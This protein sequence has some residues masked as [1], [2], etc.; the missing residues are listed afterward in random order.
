MIYQNKNFSDNDIEEFYTLCN[1]IINELTDE[2]NKYHHIRWNSNQYQILLG[3]WIYHFN[4]IILWRYYNIQRCFEKV[5]ENIV[6]VQPDYEYIHHYDF[7][8]LLNSHL[9][10]IVE[11]IIKYEK[12]PHLKFSTYGKVTAKYN[13][14]NYS[15]DNLIIDAPYFGLNHNRIHSEEYSKIIQTFANIGSVIDWEFAK[16]EV[17]VDTYWRSRYIGEKASTIYEMCLNLSRLYLPIAFLEGFKPIYN[18][19]STY[20]ISSIYTPIGIIWNLPLKTILAQNYLKNNIYLH[21]HGGG[22]GMDKFHPN[23][24]YERKICKNFFTLGWVEDSKTTP[25]SSRARIKKS[26]INSGILIKT[27]PNHRYS[28]DFFAFSMDITIQFIRNLK[29]KNCHISHYRVQPGEDEK[30]IYFTRLKYKLEDAILPDKTK[31]DGEY[32]MHVMNY[33]G[34]SFLESIAANIP[35]ICLIDNDLLDYRDE[36]INKL[37][38]LI[39]VGIVHHCGKEAAEHVNSISNDIKSWWLSD[40]VQNIRN[41]FFNQYARFND[42]WLAEFDNFFSNYKK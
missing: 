14:V 23:E 31:N 16:A 34:T 11:K 35:T 28:N 38:K 39:K 36:C 29:S 24:K 27:K 20:P 26:K 22:Y 21:Q 40:P 15:N 41:E 10:N 8:D 19:S 32:S 17:I 25:M 1:S 6:V 3:N 13:M 37:R 4:Y 30:N 18:I 33:L 7:N 12:I 2:L 42:S 9:I 5:E